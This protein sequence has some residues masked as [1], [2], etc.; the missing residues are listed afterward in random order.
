[1]VF[2]VVCILDLIRLY[3]CMNLVIN[4]FILLVFKLLI[5]MWFMLFIMLVD[6]FNRI[7]F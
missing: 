4:G 6:I 2:I 5:L 1:M 3:F 7:G